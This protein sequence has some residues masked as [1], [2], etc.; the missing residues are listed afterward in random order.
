MIIWGFGLTINCFCCFILLIFFLICSLILFS[1]FCVS[2]IFLLFLIVSFVIWFSLFAICG[3]ICN[4]LTWI[5]IG[6]KL[7]SFSFSFSFLFWLTNFESF[8][9]SL[10]FSFLLLWLFIS[11][12]FLLFS[13]SSSISSFSSW[14]KSCISST[15]CSSSSFKSSFSSY[16]SLFSSCSFCDISSSTSYCSLSSSSSLYSNLVPS[17]W[18]LSLFKIFLSLVLFWDLSPFMTILQIFWATDFNGFSSLEFLCII[19][20][21]KSPLYIKGLLR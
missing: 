20:F 3:L 16:S 18:L 21:W 10:I 15:P 1:S 2:L 17:C 6:F 4:S 5:L 9:S 8:L 13:S 7:L 11:I 12:L 14:S 19:L